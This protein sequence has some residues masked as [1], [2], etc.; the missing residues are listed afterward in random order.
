[1]GDNPNNQPL[2]V[3][4]RGRSARSKRMAAQLNQ[5]NR[6]LNNI[7][8][9]GGI[10]S[11]VYGDKIQFRGSRGPWFNLPFWY[12]QEGANGQTI[13]IRAGK[14]DIAGKSISVAETAVTLTGDPEYVYIDYPWTTSAATIEHS[15]NYPL[16]DST[17]MKY[18][19]YHFVTDANGNY[20]VTDQ[21]YLRFNVKVI[22][23]LRV[24]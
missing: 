13:T 5:T 23:P 19:L 16:D 8:A 14:L 24:S 17:S 2:R 1:M 18:P 4:Y 3:T 10:Q 9:G 6:M 7:T 12:K 21:G 22:T 20:Y 11:Q 15:S